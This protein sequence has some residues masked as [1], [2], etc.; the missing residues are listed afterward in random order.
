MKKIGIV[1]LVKNESDIIE[2]FLRI[3]LRSVDKIFL[4]DHCSQDG[5]LEIA[6]EM[7]KE[8]HQI[9]LFRY[10]NKEFNQSKV[11][12]SAVRNIA[13]KNI[14]DFIIPLDGDEFIS[15]NHPMD[16]RKILSVNVGPEEAAL[17]PWE[18]YCPTSLNYFKSEAPLFH[19][20]KKRSIEPKQY[21][22]VILG[23]EFAKDCIVEAGNHS[24]FSAKYQ[25][26][27]KTLN[28]KLKHIPVRSPEQII[29]KALMG[30]YS[31]LLKNGRK[32]GENYHW[33]EIS[34]MARKSDYV[35]KLDQLIKIALHYAASKDAEVTIDQN[36]FGIGTK[37]DKI[38]FSHLA[39][40]SL[41]RD[42]DI[43]VM[44]LI[45]IIKSNTGAAPVKAIS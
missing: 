19:C 9:E 10:A 35:I 31:N 26:P 5:T 8:Y 38:I 12:T 20:F 11:I 25:R 44:E 6:K 7:K 13:S 3:N 41:V 27:K 30:N 39:K 42:Y 36:S 37:E 21:Y 22:K 17:M 34:N 24:A 40:P 45:E 4:I 32:K 33:D 43:L 15:E 18:T 1:S 2:L 16:L 23:N 28:I 29:R 14:L